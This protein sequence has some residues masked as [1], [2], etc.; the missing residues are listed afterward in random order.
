MHWIGP[1]MDLINSNIPQ[2]YMIDPALVVGG[3]V[4][5]DLYGKYQTQ[6]QDSLYYTV[7]DMVRCFGIPLGALG[8]AT[9]ARSIL[10]GDLQGTQCLTDPP[11]NESSTRLEEDPAS[12]FLHRLQGQ[13]LETN[14]RWAIERNLRTQLAESI[15]MQQWTEAVDI[16]ISGIEHGLRNHA[17]L[18]M[19]VAAS[20]PLEEDPTGGV[21]GLYLI[22]LMQ[23]HR[24]EVNESLH[25]A[26]ISLAGPARSNLRS[27]IVNHQLEASEA[28]GDLLR[29]YSKILPSRRQS[30]EDG[31]PE[32]SPQHLEP[33]F[34]SCL[35]TAILVYTRANAW[36]KMLSCLVDTGRYWLI[37]SFALTIQHEADWPSLVQHVLRAN[38]RNPAVHFVNQIAEAFLDDADLHQALAT[39]LPIEVLDHET[40]L[41]ALRRT[42]EEVN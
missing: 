24:L 33:E 23:F 38:G 12:I 25:F 31:M 21:A 5:I 9:L 8:C 13:I 7:L 42:E 11:S 3:Y 1:R 14:I 4:R 10:R 39:V 20:P 41:D 19:F 18:D 40:P 28:L 26:R 30:L 27:F 2:T 16:A 17:T 34:I 29:E 36:D 15:S 6:P 32:P 22:R 37:V 35:E